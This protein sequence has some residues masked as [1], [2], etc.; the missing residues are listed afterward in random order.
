MRI[1]LVVSGVI[2][3]V[4]T[5]LVTGRWLTQFTDSIWPLSL[6]RTNTSLVRFDNRVFQV[7]QVRLDTL[8][9]ETLP[10]GVTLEVD[11]SGIATLR[12][13]G[14]AFRC[15]S[16][17]SV[18]KGDIA[19]V[20]D[21]N[22]RVVFAT[23]RSRLSWPTPLEMNFMT[24]SAPTWRRY[25]Y[26]RLSWLKADGERLELVWRFRQGYFA[27]DGWRPGTIESG[28]AGLWRIEIK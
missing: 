18:E 28:S 13:Q 2:V 22:D 19:I 26:C 4:V 11:P 10:S 27:N 14:K 17:R 9:P 21:K 20:P 7:E 24:G 5:W 12:Y 8:T 15:G 3:L 16:A 1:L 25:L 6:T 23:E